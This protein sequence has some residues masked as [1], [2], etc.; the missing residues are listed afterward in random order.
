MVHIYET[1]FICVVILTSVCCR[2]LHSDEVDGFSS[3]RSTMGSASKVISFPS[4]VRTHGPL[5][6]KVSCAST[7][8]PYLL[9]TSF[10]LYR[11]LYTCPESIHLLRVLYLGAPRGPRLTLENLGW[12][13]VRPRCTRA[14][15]L[16]GG[17]P[18]AFP[19][20]LGPWTSLPRSQNPRRA[21]LM[22]LLC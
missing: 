2:N 10:L 20:S 13:L 1:C 15:E 3:Y 6:E 16:Y 4:N 12:A 19:P 11:V 17:E 5:R 7:E 22:L 8:P 18:W 9:R 21:P 14:W